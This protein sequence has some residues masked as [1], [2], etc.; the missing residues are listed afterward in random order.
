MILKIKKLFKHA[1]VENI[2]IEGSITT[3]EAVKPIESILPLAESNR[4][5]YTHTHINNTKAFNEV[6]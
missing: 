4:A 2:F 5:I 3:A 1:R 6:E